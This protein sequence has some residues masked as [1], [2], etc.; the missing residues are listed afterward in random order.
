MGDNSGSPGIIIENH[1]MNSEYALLCRLRDKDEKAVYLLYRDYFSTVEKYI[2][3]NS[4]SK[5]DAEDIFQ[6]AVLIL[7]VKV[8]A[9]S[10]L[11]SASL[12]TFLFSICRNL[13]LKQ[14]RNTS[15][16]I[17]AKEWESMQLSFLKDSAEVESSERQ[18]NTLPEVLKRITKHCSG[19]LKELF[20]TGRIPDHYKNTHTLSNQKYKC[21]DQARRVVS[22]LAT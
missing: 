7:L 2:V 13:W 14:L 6:E 22:K 10:F 20:L 8:S 17:D 18:W 1:Q 9:E 16:K 19:L 15:R 12:K 3:M 11:L 21:L 5:E 4:G